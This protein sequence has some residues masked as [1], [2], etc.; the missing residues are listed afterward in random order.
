VGKVETA[1]KR[2]QAR[3]QSKR[4]REPGGIVDDTPVRQPGDELVSARA[5]SYARPQLHAGGLIPPREHESRIAGEFRSIK[6]PLIANALG[7]SAN[8]DGRSNVIQV[9]SAVSG[10]G[11]TFCAFN[12]AESLAQEQDLDIVLIDGDVVMPKLSEILGEKG[13][14]GL[15]DILSDAAV[16]LKDVLLATDTDR[17]W[18]IPSGT[19]RHQAHELLAGRRMGKL[20]DALAKDRQCIVIIDSPPMLLA[21]EAPVLTSHVGQVLLVVSALTTSQAK[22]LEVISLI[23]QDKALNL[24]LNRASGDTSATY[25]AEYGT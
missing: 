24:V 20:L 16:E 4:G 11:K 25:G 14:P 17:L 19:P 21:N 22:V 15:L 10:E 7:K 8:G 12:L 6:R 2:I 5:I 13:A 1:I 3:G 18:F 23:E 9:T